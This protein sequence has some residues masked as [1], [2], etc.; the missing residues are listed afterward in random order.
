MLCRLLFS[1]DVLRRPVRRKSRLALRATAVEDPWSVL[2]IPSSSTFSDIKWAYKKKA[3]REHPDIS[4]APDAID[5]WQRVSRAYESLVAARDQLKQDATSSYKQ[6]ANSIY[7]SRRVPRPPSLAEVW[8]WRW[9]VDKAALVGIAANETDRAFEIGAPSVKP[10]VA[11]VWLAR[12]LRETQFEFVDVLAQ[13]SGIEAI[14]A[15]CSLRAAVCIAAG[16]RTSALSAIREMLHLRN[17]HECV[18]KQLF[19]C[20]ETVRYLKTL[21]TRNA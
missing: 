6:A 7:R 17:R 9:S 2:G 14:E 18:V 12:E 8:D 5:R 10:R 13:A 16:E 1:S 20:W 11:E 3:L 19:R 4:T 21:A 15:E